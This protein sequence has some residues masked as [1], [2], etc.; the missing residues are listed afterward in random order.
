MPVHPILVHFPLALLTVGLLADIVGV[1]A[2]RDPF[3]VGGWWLQC[4][5]TAGLVAAVLSGLYAKSV[6]AVLPSALASLDIHQQVAFVT[7]SVYAGLFLWRAARKSRIPE[8]RYVFLAAYA[9]A[10]IL[11]WITGWL[12]G[13]LVYGHGIGTQAFTP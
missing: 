4:C 10:T 1:V 8:A 7:S 12:G 6:A 13:E 11:L 9:A 2:R 3:S 5:G